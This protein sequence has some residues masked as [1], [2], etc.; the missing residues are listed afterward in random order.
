MLSEG[1][2]GYCLGSTLEQRVET[3]A[4]RLS[5]KQTNKQKPNQPTNQTN[6]K[7]PGSGGTRL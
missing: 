5:K 3:L 4:F 2:F 1:H 6:K 7:Q